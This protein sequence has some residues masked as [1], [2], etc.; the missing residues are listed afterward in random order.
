MEFPS[1]G[2]LT[3]DSSRRLTMQGLLNEEWMTGT[4]LYPST[5][6]LTPNV[7]HSSTSSQHGGT[8]TAEAGVKH[9][10]YAFHVATRQGFRLQVRFGG[11]GVGESWMCVVRVGE[12]P[13]LCWLWESDLDV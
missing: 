13:G 4:L 5:P 1:V 3:V 12:C 10:F 11:S 7:L 6:L 2:L 9:A 8:P